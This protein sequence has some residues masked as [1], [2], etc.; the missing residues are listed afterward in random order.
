VE[1]ECGGDSYVSASHTKEPRTEPARADGQPRE[2]SRS[3]LEP[4]ACKG[5]SRTQRRVSTKSG[6][7][8]RDMVHC[9]LGESSRMR[10]NPKATLIA[11]AHHALTGISLLEN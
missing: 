9:G 11:P 7:A 4:E 1:Q 2:L 8:V 10:G 5:G 3:E 6:T